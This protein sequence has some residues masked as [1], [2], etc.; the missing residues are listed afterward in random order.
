M[1]FSELVASEAEDSLAMEIGRLL[2]IKINAPETLEIPR[3]KPLNAYIDETLPLLKAQAEALPT[4]NPK[5]FDALDKLF[6]ETLYQ[7]HRFSFPYLQGCT[8]SNLC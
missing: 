2:D 6:I 5:G 8:E 7:N 4:V 1:L 3:I